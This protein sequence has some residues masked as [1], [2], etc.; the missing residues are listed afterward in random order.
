MYMCGL[1]EPHV[2]LVVG[3]TNAVYLW[4][5]QNRYYPQLRRPHV[6]AETTSQAIDIALLTPSSHTGS[7]N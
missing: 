1:I 7:N 6:V 2:C 5:N 3:G 4:N